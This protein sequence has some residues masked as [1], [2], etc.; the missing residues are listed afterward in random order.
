MFFFFLSF[1]VFQFEFEFV[2]VLVLGFAVDFSFVDLVCL[3]LVD[4]SVLE[5]FGGLQ[6]CG[7]LMNEHV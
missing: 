5:L 3:S 1:S 4:F 6:C 7:G 2:L